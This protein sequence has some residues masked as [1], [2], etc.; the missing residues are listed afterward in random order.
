M[1]S[2]Y[3]TRLYKSLS[4]QKRSSSKK[5]GSRNTSS[6]RRRLSS[7]KTIKSVNLDQDYHKRHKYDFLLRHNA[8]LLEYL[9]NILHGG[10]IKSPN[11]LKINSSSEELDAI[12]FTPVPHNF[13]YNDD[14]D[15]FSLYLDYE[16]VLN[17]YNSYFINNSNG[18][19]PLNGKYPKK[20]HKKINRC[21]K[22]ETYHHNLDPIKYPNVEHNPCH[23]TYNKMMKI[24]NSLK[25]E[26]FLEEDGPEVGFITPKISL[27]NYLKY[28]IVS[29]RT[30]LIKH[31]NVKTFLKKINK[32]IDEVYEEMKEITERYGGKFI[33]LANV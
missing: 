5:R 33:E 1:N 4:S 3:K 27:Q 13:I 12:F 18:F 15:S 20:M 9:Y 8:G 29:D 2:I 32:S 10:Y 11:E 24:I 21:H 14:I 16:K 7:R 23:I 22:W 30:T 6:I 26:E 28:I 31:I 25:H 19:K 17:H